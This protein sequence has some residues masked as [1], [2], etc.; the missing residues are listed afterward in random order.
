MFKMSITIMIPLLGD[1]KF[2]CV[3]GR[4]GVV[5]GW[6]DLEGGGRKDLEGVPRA[7]KP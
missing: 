2:L 5:W 7:P 1:D 3:T 4:L 6:L